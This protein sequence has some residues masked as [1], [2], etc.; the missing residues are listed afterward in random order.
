MISHIFSIY[1]KKKKNPRNFCQWKWSKQVIHFQH[2]IPDCIFFFY[3]IR[4][5]NKLQYHC[6]LKR[7][8][9]AQGLIFIDR[10][11]WLFIGCA[12]PPYRAIDL[13][14]GI[15]HRFAVVFQSGLV[16]E[17]VDERRSDEFS[18]TPYFSCVLSKHNIGWLRFHDWKRHSWSL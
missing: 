1:I 2:S 10:Q 4:A 16:N 6:S 18:V 9:R 12:F 13:K 8:W 15:G 3:P 14:V 5:M 7:I 11:G 17:S